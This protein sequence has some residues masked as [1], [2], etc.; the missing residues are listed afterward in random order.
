MVSLNTNI[1][2]GCHIILCWK[3]LQKS[4]VPNS[5]TSEFAEPTKYKVTHTHTHIFRNLKREDKIQ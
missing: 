3:L 4:F 5:E 2:F 1:V